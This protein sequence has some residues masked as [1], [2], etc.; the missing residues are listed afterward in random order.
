MNNSISEHR[1]RV[2]LLPGA[3]DEQ[4]HCVTQLTLT[5]YD[6]RRGGLTDGPGIFR[7]LEIRN[8][9]PKRVFD[10]P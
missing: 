5:R 8:N 3:I 1:C 10:V 6:L 9:I 2:L 4:T 7:E